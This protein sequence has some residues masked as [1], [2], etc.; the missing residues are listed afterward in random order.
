M[1][2]FAAGKQ[3]LPTEFFHKLDYTI[4]KSPDVDRLRRVRKGDMSHGCERKAQ[5]P[6]GQAPGGNA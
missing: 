1:G 2:D 6:L 4:S 3:R 5:G